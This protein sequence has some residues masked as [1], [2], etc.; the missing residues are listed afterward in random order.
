M[1]KIVRIIARLNI[2][3]PARNAVLLSE[4]FRNTVL[5]CGEVDRSEGDMMYLA[6][7]KCIEPVIVPELGRELSWGDDWAA[8][9]KIYKIIREEKPDII[10]TH[11]AKAGT[12]GR[13][14]GMLY[15]IGITLRNLP[16]SPRIVEASRGGKP[17]A[18]SNAVA[19]RL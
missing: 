19:R 10:H 1:I 12:L 4:G 15:N 8:F 11:T 14:A 17:A 9:W 7:E 3:G 2:G 13:L 16:V 5:V 18:T 6:R